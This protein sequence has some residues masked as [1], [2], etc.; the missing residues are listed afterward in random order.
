MKRAHHLDADVALFRKLCEKRLVRCDVKRYCEKRGKNHSLGE[1]RRTALKVHHF[2]SPALLEQ[3][4]SVISE[5]FRSCDYAWYRCG[6]INDK[7]MRD[8]TVG[9]CIYH[10]TEES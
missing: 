3:I 7:P 8:M 5:F 4:N 6:N 1:Y 10:S 2:N 9:V